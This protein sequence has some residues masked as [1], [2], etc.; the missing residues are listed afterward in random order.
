MGRIY[1]ENAVAVGHKFHFPMGE[2]LMH[3]NRTPGGDWQVDAGGTDVV[4]IRAVA[5]GFA[6]GSGS[7]EARRSAF[8]S[9]MQLAILRLGLQPQRVERAR[10]GVSGVHH[11]AG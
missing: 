1:D 3:V 6:V 7:D 2:F 8:A 4:T 10:G 5:G 11:A 9:A